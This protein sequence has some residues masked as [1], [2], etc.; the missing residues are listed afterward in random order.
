MQVTYGEVKITDTAARRVLLA[1]D[2]AI[3]LEQFVQRSQQRL[4]IERAAIAAPRSI[5]IAD[6]R[7]GPGW[8]I[9]AH[10]APVGEA[11]A[12]RGPAAILIRCP[13]IT[14]NNIPFTALVQI[15]Q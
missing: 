4:K 13:R 7:N 3:M 10:I 14:H 12:I 8:I 11:I 2:L 1:G 15:D 6:G 9:G 5:R